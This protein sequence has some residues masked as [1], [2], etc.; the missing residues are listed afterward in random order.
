MIIRHTLYRSL[1]D[2]K[3]KAYVPQEFTLLID[4][5]KVPVTMFNRAR[6]SWKSTAKAAHGTLTI[7]HKGDA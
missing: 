5:D 2:E 1:W 6:T 4:T 3:R 7:V